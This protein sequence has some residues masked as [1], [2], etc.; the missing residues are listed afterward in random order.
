MKN[1]GVFWKTI[2]NLAKQSAIPLVIS[3][4]Y[5]GWVY[6]NKGDKVYATDAISA[7]GAAFFFCMWLLGQ[8]FRTSKQLSD[9]ENFNSL[10]AGIE[11]IN[12]SIRELRAL[13]V[14]APM[15]SSAPPPSNQLMVQAKQLVQSGHVLAG[16]LQAG[17]AFEQAVH[18]K[19]QR[20]G[21]H[22]Q[23]FHSFPQLLQ[24]IEEQLGPGA[25]KELQALWRFRNQI[26]HADSQASEELQQ[27]PEL[28]DFFDSGI[29]MLGPDRDAF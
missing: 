22:R 3:T 26:V 21:L 29:K 5:A 1:Q 2:G 10:S 4:I 7:F 23:N 16:I 27:R 15:S 28:V 14:P 8:F 25:G 20:T 6:L 13:P 12:N 11:D 9:S 17:V 18:A 24:R 19:A